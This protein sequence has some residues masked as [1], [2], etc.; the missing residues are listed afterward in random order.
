ML[1]QFVFSGRYLAAGRHPSSFL[2]PHR[3]SHAHIHHLFIKFSLTISS[4]LLSCLLGL[5]DA[6]QKRPHLSC[7]IFFVIYHCFALLSA[8]VLSH[9]RRFWSRLL[10]QHSV[11]CHPQSFVIYFFFGNP[12]HSYPVLL[13]QSPWI[14][15]K[16]HIR[17]AIT[18]S[19]LAPTQFQSYT[20]LFSSSQLFHSQR[21]PLFT[22]VLFLLFHTARAGWVPSLFIIPTL[23]VSMESDFI[24]CIDLFRRT[25]LL[26]T[27]DLA[28]FRMAHTPSPVLQVGY[29]M[30][31]HNLDYSILNL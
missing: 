16:W 11:A 31:R 13:A 5:L 2:E 14:S 22:L 15:L 25:I 7:T 9:L 30:D 24:S 26:R 3:T 20:T 8:P 23:S 6:L 17:P 21:L 12:V 19:F 1:G 28:S 4:Y 18:H 29:C 10:T 27:G